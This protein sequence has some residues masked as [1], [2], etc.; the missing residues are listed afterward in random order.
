MTNFLYNVMMRI[1]NRFGIR[2]GRSFAQQ[3]FRSF[4]T[5]ARHVILLFV[6]ILVY[7]IILFSNPQGI[8]IV[9]E[10]IKNSRYWVWTMLSLFAFSMSLW[11]CAT[12]L[13]QLKQISHDRAFIKANA[14]GMMFWL[15]V[16]PIFLSSLPFV[17]LLFKPDLYS[18]NAYPLIIVIGFVLFVLPLVLTEFFRLLKLTFQN[19]RW[20]HGISAQKQTLK[21]L[22]F[23]RGTRMLFYFFLAYTIILFIL[24]LTSVETGFA[25]KVGPIAVMVF[26]LSFLSMVFSTLMYFNIPG[27]RPFLLYCVIL[28]A[29][30]SAINDN[31]HI[32]TLPKTVARPPLESDF[33]KWAIELPNK[34]SLISLPDTI[35]APPESNASKKPEKQPIPIFFVAA[36]GGGIRALSWTALVLASLEKKYPGIHWHIYGISGA[37]GGGV[38]AT[39]YMYYLHDQLA[40]KTDPVLYEASFRR[41]IRNDFLSDVLAACM[42]QDNLQNILPIGVPSFDRTRRLEDAWSK[43]FTYHTNS[44]SFESGFLSLYADTTLRLPRLFLN[45]VLAETG[46]KTIVTYPLLHSAPAPDINEPDVLKDELDVIASIGKDIP[47]KTVASLCSRF[48]YITSGGLISSS[49]G[50]K[51]GHVIDGGYKENTGLETVWQLLLRLKPV[52]IKV[53]NSALFKQNGIRLKPVVIFVKNSPATDV[54]DEKTKIAGMLHE[55]S[56]PIIGFMNAS[57]RKTPT[58]DALTENVFK[59]YNDKNSDLLPC[60][61]IRIDLDRSSKQGFNLPLGWYFSDGSFAYVDQKLKESF[62]DSSAF[63]KKIGAYTKQIFKIK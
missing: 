49:G 47:V 58:I 16:L 17:L 46:Q 3:L 54:L 33:E 29:I 37:S 18:E 35:L 36:E 53:E 40:A 2:V 28:I 25:V 59:Y 43:A 41:S 38:G 48:P 63:S 9:N 23:F 39:F 8:D 6:L 12:L 34:D 42:F 27:R 5:V 55:I 15:V 20:F 62:Q 10:V 1:L 32:R 60:E 30:F 56:M 14:A 52:I 7:A 4:W 26:G 61:Y 51:I 31:S 13:F 24:S 19:V 11:F 44:D 50:K 22:L 21:S 57:D 45:G